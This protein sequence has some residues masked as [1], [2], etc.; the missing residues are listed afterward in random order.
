MLLAPIFLQGNSA[1][2]TTSATPSTSR[3]VPVPVSSMG[4][5]GGVPQI[6]LLNKG[7]VDVW[8]SFTSPAAAAAVIPTAGTEATLG[9]PQ[10]VLWLAPGIEI[11]LSLPCSIAPL[12]GVTNTPVGFWVNHISTVA[13][14]V[15]QLQLGDGT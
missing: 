10:A 14:Q 5:S 12:T 8:L 15:F 9:T 3:S 1:I 6:R 4:V 11:T 7:T 2:L 13:S